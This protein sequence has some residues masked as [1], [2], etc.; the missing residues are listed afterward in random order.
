MASPTM[1][2]AFPHPTSIKKMFYRL[3]FI[4]RHFLE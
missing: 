4:L 3:A 2:Q 1:G